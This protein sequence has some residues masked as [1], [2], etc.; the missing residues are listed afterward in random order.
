MKFI[1]GGDGALITCLKCNKIGQ[2]ANFCPDYVDAGEQHHMNTVD[3][4][5]DTVREVM[6]N[7]EGTGCGVDKETWTSSGLTLTQDGNVSE[8]ECVDSDN[9]SMI[10]TFQSI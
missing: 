10:I 7:A 6:A 1:Q 4:K 3:V 8:E 9:D 2:F 5:G